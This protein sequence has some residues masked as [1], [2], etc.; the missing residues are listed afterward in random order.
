LQPP[1]YPLDLAAEAARLVREATGSG[2]SRVDPIL[3]GHMTF[4]LSVTSDSGR[5][6]IVRIYPKGREHIARFEP[7][8]LARLREC[9]AA[10]PNVVGWS[11]A[12]SA[13]P[14]LVYEKIAGESLDRRLGA[15]AMP[16]LERICAQMAAQLAI[17]STLPVDGFGDLI[18]VDRAAQPRW[19]DFVE[20]VVAAPVS[21][22]STDRALLEEARAAMESLKEARADDVARSLVWTDISPENII[23]DS[24]DRFAGLIDFEGTMALEPEAT[25]G[26]LEARYCGTP[27]HRACRALMPVAP[28]R[29]R[30]PSFYAVVRALRLQPYL[31]MELPAGGRREPLDK[32][33][34]GLEDACRQVIEWGEAQ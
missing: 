9:G 6:Y 31:Q 33:L 28:E 7:A 21:A 5:V 4:K 13:L 15:L 3:S 16:G 20:T 2:V 24:D 12:E 22:V 11:G 18:G 25:L 10:V 30:L 23:V 27:F 34:P 17:L 1:D 19:Q 14:H 32:F 26:Y 8:L 29:R